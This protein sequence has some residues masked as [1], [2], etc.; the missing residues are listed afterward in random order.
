MTSL[1]LIALG[2]L[3]MGL[4]DAW[5]VWLLVRFCVGVLSAWVLVL[6]MAK[7]WNLGSSPAGMREKRTQLPALKLLDLLK[8]PTKAHNYRARPMKPC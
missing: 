5:P 2:T 6:A 4:S 8:A 7:G 3:G 1:L